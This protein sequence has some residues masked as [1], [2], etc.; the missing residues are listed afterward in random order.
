[1]MLSLQNQR[2]DP[3]TQHGGENWKL[4]GLVSLALRTEN[5]NFVNYAPIEGTR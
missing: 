5:K 1:M 2:D 4:V 3:I